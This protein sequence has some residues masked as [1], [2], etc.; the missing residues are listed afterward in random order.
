MGK[1]PKQANIYCPKCGCV[2]SGRAGQLCPCCEDVKLEL[3]SGEPGAGARRS[4]EDTTL[5]QKPSTAMERT[6]PAKGTAESRS[7]QPMLGLRKLPEGRPRQR[8]LH[9]RGGYGL[10]HID[11]GVLQAEEVS[12]WDES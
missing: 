11:E 10:R 12:G 9:A 5:A 4:I 8:V 3:C 7:R 1:K 6:N 2:F